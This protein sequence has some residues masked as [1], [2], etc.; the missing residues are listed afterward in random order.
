MT[1]LD[2]RRNLDQLGSG[3][4]PRPCATSI[5]ALRYAHANHLTLAVGCKGETWPADVGTGDAL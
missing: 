1:E 3:H 5:R 4:T 2:A